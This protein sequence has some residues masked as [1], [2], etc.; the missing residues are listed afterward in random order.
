VEAMLTMVARPA[1]PDGKSALMLVA[2]RLRHVD[3]TRILSWVILR[4]KL[5]L[6]S[7]LLRKTEV[8][9]QSHTAHLHH[10]KMVNK[11]H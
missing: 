7:F 5:R 9:T 4:R 1:G 6:S 2:A 8:T 11:A 3:T 10:I